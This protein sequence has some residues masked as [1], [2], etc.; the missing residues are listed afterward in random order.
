MRSVYLLLVLLFTVFS[1]EALADRRIALVIGN[2]AYQKVRRLPNSTNDASDM[3]LKLKGLGFEVVSGSDLEFATMR[4]AVRNFIQKLNTADIALFYY[5]GH[6]LQ[7]DGINYMVPVDAHLASYDDLDFEVLSMDLV[8]AAMERNSK[9]SLVFLDA[10]RDNPFAR[11]LAQSMGTRS[12]SV[13]EG[14]AKLGGGVGSL[15]AFATQPGNVAFDGVGRNSPFTT[16]LLR[17][18]G[19]P[20]QDVTRDLIYARRD[21]LE[22]THGKQVPWDNSSLTGEVVLNPGVAPEPKS[23]SPATNTPAKA[24]TAVEIAYWE[25]IKDSGNKNF[26]QA[27]LERYPNGAFAA[28]AKLKIEVLDEEKRRLQGET[29][30]TSSDKPIGRRDDEGYRDLALSTQRELSRVGCLAGQIDGKWGLAS[31]KALQDFARLRG[32]NLASAEPS[33]DVLKR[34][35]E[36]RDTICPLSCPDGTE[37]RGGRCRSTVGGFDGMWALTRRAT[38]PSCGWPELTSNIWIAD[39]QIHSPSWEGNVAP[40]GVSTIILRFVHKGRNERNILYV[41]LR[42][43]KG[44]GKFYHVGGECAGVVELRKL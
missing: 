17:H 22:A 14:L 36:I 33:A 18:L 16:A 25:T 42:G 44:A 19:T 20:G 28:L 12:A 8:V 13:G 3:A 27:Y 24:E 5:S 40:N 26:F 15:I 29:Q 34:L 43:N 7:V 35:Q 41:K 37:A 23:E 2:S 38:N 1:A 6:G 31:K 21:V 9:V 32:I 11:N 4:G 30:A 10:C 39:G